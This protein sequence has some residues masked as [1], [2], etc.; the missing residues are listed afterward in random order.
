VSPDNRRLVL[1]A[2]GPTWPGQS[3]PEWGPLP[4]YCHWRQFRRLDL[5][6]ALNLS[7][8]G[9]GELLTLA[10]QFK[11]GSF[12]YGRQ[13]PGGPDDWK[14][15]NYL[16]DRG[17]VPRSLARGRPPGALGRAGLTYV[18][19]AASAPPALE[20]A[21]QGRRVLLIPPVAE[22]TAADLPAARRLE[23]LVLPAKLAAP[24]ERQLIMGR[25]HPDRLVIY[26]DPRRSGAARAGCPIPCQFT[27]EGAVSLYLAASGVTANQWRPN[28]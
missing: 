16:G 2:M 3:S 14:F 10:R 17:A 24:R 9:A 4:E 23:V 7:E 12:W 25:L 11:V 18:K 20:V 6:V 21:F 5:V 1:S 27:R 8:A 26:G 13:G 22:L 28:F 15:W 19:L